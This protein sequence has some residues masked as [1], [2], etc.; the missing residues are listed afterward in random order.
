MVTCTSI[1]VPTDFSERSLVALDYGRALADQF[2]STLH[3]LHVTSPAVGV[4]GA[5]FWG[6]SDSDLGSRLEEEARH[7][8]EALLPTLDG[9][10]ASVVTRF[11]YPSVEIVR[12]ARDRNVDLIVM[13]THGHG[14]LA[15]LL[16]GG[17]V[18]NVIRRAPCPVLAVHTPRATLRPA[19]TS[20]PMGRMGVADPVPRCRRGHARSRSVRSHVCAERSMYTSTS[21]SPTTRRVR[22]EGWAYLP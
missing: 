20:H 19:L 3:V 22:H 15:H 1:L 7:Q 10:Q 4:G 13:G 8:F 14:R 11:G 2:L 6:F 21:A 5:T 17:V 16:V 12:F 9:L 18:E